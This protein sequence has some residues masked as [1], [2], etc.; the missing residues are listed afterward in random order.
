MWVLRS[1]TCL[2]N[3]NVYFCWVC[4]RFTRVWFASSFCDAKVPKTKPA[5]TREEDACSRLNISGQREEKRW[6]AESSWDW[7]RGVEGTHWRK[8]VPAVFGQGEVFVK[9][10]RLRNQKHSCLLSFRSR[11]HRTAELTATTTWSEKIEEEF[12]D[13]ISVNKAKWRAEGTKHGCVSNCPLHV[14]TLQLIMKYFEAVYLLINDYEPVTYS[15]LYLQ[16]R[17]E[18][19]WMSGQGEVSYEKYEITFKKNLCFH[20]EVLTFPS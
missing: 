19:N 18:H 7:Q 1:R 13:W 9:L 10:H 17:P 8:T 11:F 12:H 3:T 15:H 4:H 2:K 14:N 16:K 6:F 20:R 5:L